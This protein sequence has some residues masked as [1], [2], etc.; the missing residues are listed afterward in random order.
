M[1]DRDHYPLAAAIVVAGPTLFKI[2]LLLFAIAAGICMML[3]YISFMI[4]AGGLAT[5][6]VVAIVSSIVNGRRLK[7]AML[8]SDAP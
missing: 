2:A 4:G 3:G 6:I 5:V 1:G 7:K 8:E